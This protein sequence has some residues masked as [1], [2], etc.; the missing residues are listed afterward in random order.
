MAYENYRYVAWASGTPITGER[1]SQMSNN[2]EQVKEAT[3]DVPRGIVRL[4]QV[5]TDVPNSTGFSG[6][7]EHQI[8]SLKEDP[9]SD[10][11]VTLPAN[12]LYRMTLSFPGFV[13]RARGA[14]DSTFLIRFYQGIFGSASV[15]LNTWRLTVPPFGYYNVATD[16]ATLDIIPKSI[17]YSTRVGAGDYSVIFDSGLGLSGESY[18]VAV[19]RD[20]GASP[21]NAPNYFIPSSGT[22]MQ[23]YIEDVGGS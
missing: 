6:F 18:Y 15:L 3:D 10:K 22:I 14:E 11:R 19:K 23:L 4:E 8:I 7:N 12:R 9:P 2:I 1:L 21:D 16:P 5:T 17:G 13:V 20:Q